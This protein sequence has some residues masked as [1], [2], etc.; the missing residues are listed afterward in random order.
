MSAHARHSRN[1]SGGEVLVRI[2]TIL[3]LITA[4]AVFVPSTS[5]AENLIAFV[6]EK[7]SVTEF[8][9]ETAPDA[10]LM[11][12][13]FKA[14][15]RVIEVIYGT[16]A[17][18]TLEFEAYDHYG[19]PGFENH[20]HVLLFVSSAGGAFYHQKYQYFPVFKTKSG[21]WAGCGDPYQFEPDMHRGII[22][23]HSLDFNRDAYFDIS[24]HS[25]REKREYFPSEYFQIRDG[26]AYCKK[27]NTVQELFEVKKQGVLK[28]RGLFEEDANQSLKS[29]VAEATRP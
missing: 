22:S 1:V 20:R 10:I 14:R 7:I 9:P 2:A 21:R 16:Y 18:K 15:Y 13:A 29:D 28:A 8:E 25:R 4:I 3:V 24:R 6:G 5:R 17:E 11:D 27:G 26:K 23:A 12:S 19:R